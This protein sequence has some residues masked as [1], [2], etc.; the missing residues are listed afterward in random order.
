MAKWGKEILILFKFEVLKE[1]GG[2]FFQSS[3]GKLALDTRDWIIIPYDDYKELD[4][5]TKSVTHQE[6]KKKNQE[7]LSQAQSNKFQWLHLKLKRAKEGQSV[8]DKQ[9]IH[10]SMCSPGPAAHCAPHPPCE[11]SSWHV[12][13]ISRITCVLNDVFFFPVT[14]I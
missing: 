13:M 8:S 14:D 5:H 12:F 3:G 11:Q 7:V 1:M 9:E 2:I 10:N 4:W 6:R